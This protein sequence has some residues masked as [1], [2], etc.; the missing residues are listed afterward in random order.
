MEVGFE[1]LGA[2][3]QLAGMGP[4]PLDI[5]FEPNACQAPSPSGLP[6]P[7]FKRT[8]S[9]FDGFDWPSRR[10][11]RCQSGFRGARTGRRHSS[12]SHLRPMSAGASSPTANLSARATTRTVLSCGGAKSS[13]GRSWLPMSSRL[14]GTSDHRTSVCSRAL[15][16]G[17]I[18]FTDPGGSLR[19]L[20]RIQTRLRILC[21]VS[22]ANR[23]AESA[24]CARQPLHVA[25]TR[26]MRSPGISVSDSDR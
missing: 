1:L 4:F 17:A 8:H 16:S 19:A 15:Y 11:P 14:V 24:F 3:V 25:R 21:V 18:Q 7:L 22:T 9:C 23:R 26:G 10:A 6:T 2:L 20:A 13:G 12:S 5:L